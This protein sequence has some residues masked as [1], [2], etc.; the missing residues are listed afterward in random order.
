MHGKEKQLGEHAAHLGQLGSFA[1]P[2]E[3]PAHPVMGLDEARALLGI[4]EMGSRVLAEVEGGG[5]LGHLSS[6]ESEEVEPEERP[7]RHQSGG[8]GGID[9]RLHP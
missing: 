5:E 2:K 1:H 3:G 4:Q 8:E 7:G 9:F 6:L